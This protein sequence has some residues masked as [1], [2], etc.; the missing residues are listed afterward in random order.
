MIVFRRPYPQPGMPIYQGTTDFYE[1]QIVQL[2][3]AEEKQFVDTYFAEYYKNENDYYQ[4]YDMVSDRA[5]RVTGVIGPNGF[6]STFSEFVSVKDFGAVGDGVTDDTAAIQAAINSVPRGGCL[7]FNEAKIYRI[8]S[9]LLGYDI[10]IDGA[11]SQIVSVG[12]FAQIRIRNDKGVLSTSFSVTKNQFVF[13]IGVSNNI[14][15]GD[16]VTFSSNTPRL[17]IAQYNHGFHATVINVSE[18]IITVD[19][20]AYENFTVNSI[21]VYGKSNGVTIKNLVSS[22]TITAP[23]GVPAFNVVGNNVLFLGCKVVSENENGA[24]GIL[25]LGTNIKVLNCYFQ[26]FLNINGDGG[27]GRVGYGS[28]LFGNNLSW[29]NC[30]FVEC[31][32]GQSSGGRGAVDTNVSVRGCYFFA[33]NINVGHQID[34][35]AGVLDVFIAENNYVD[36]WEACIGVRN[37]VARIHGNTLKKSST[38]GPYFRIFEQTATDIVF[39]K[40]N[41][42]GQPSNVVFLSGAQAQDPNALQNLTISGNVIDGSPILQITNGSIKNIKINGNFAR[43]AGYVMLFEAININGFMISQNDVSCANLISNGSST[44]PV[45]VINSEISENM[46]QATSGSNGIIRLVSNAVNFQNFDFS[47]NSVD[48]TLMSTNEYAF[49]IGSLCSISKSTISRNKISRGNFRLFQVVGSSTSKPVLSSV[50][51]TSNVVDGIV[52]FKDVDALEIDVSQNLFSTSTTNIASVSFSSVLN[53]S[54]ARNVRIGDNEFNSGNSNATG[55]VVEIV[56]VVSY[57]NPLVIESN[58]FHTASDLAHAVVCSAASTNN[59]IEFKNNTARR[60]FLDNAASFAIVPIGN[61]I[62]GANKQVWKGGVIVDQRGEYYAEAAPTTGAW[63]SGDRVYD[64]TPAAGGTIGFV[65]TA[66][67]TPGTWKTWGTIAA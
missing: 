52:Q 2:S 59:Q 53:T 9:T 50:S 65:C 16:I 10:S 39:S 43:N 42:S 3:D 33:R 49:N 47:E 35:H 27:G 24:R 8:T 32:H 29:E 41:V 4:P 46:I 20:S 63:L 19:R 26:G 61:Y 31:K 30:S 36:T 57:T 21:T 25:A 1:G 56:G 13:D 38:T 67:G 64:P 62:Y 66:S 14:E 58:K 51:I 60:G 5:G 18:N 17:T 37:G 23:S 44:T 22:Q 40:N 28:E 55:G 15:V 11:G 12:N 54:T 34:V 6:T 45:T 48:A 7:K